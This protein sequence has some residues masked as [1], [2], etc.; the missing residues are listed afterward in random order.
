MA[1]D[2]VAC[3]HTFS[4]SHLRLLKHVQQQDAHSKVF[5]VQV[6][7]KMLTACSD[8]PCCCVCALLQALDKTYRAE[9]SVLDT[10]IELPSI[11]AFGDALFC[12]ALLKTLILLVETVKLVCCCLATCVV[13]LVT[14]IAQPRATFH[15]TA[16]QVKNAARA[17]WAS[18]KAAVMGVLGQVRFCS[19]PCFQVH[20]VS[21]PVF[22]HSN[23]SHSNS[24][25]SRHAFSAVL[26]DGSTRTP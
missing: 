4:S 7:W 2:V 16:S 18:S 24:T 14:A 23:D 10:F 1:D 19:V 5:Q 11:L 6:M 9:A 25:C 22:T 12:A 3:Q 26:Q 17:V 20:S 21:G 13:F 15:A 8:L